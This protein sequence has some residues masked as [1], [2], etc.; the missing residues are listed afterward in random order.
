MQDSNKED[1]KIIVRKEKKTNIDFSTLENILCVKPSKLDRDDIEH[2]LGSPDEVIISPENVLELHYNRDQCTFFIHEDYLTLHFNSIKLN[3]NEVSVDQTE[4]SE[5][6]TLIKKFH[7][8]HQITY[9]VEV[10]DLHDEKM[11]TFDNIGLTVWFENQIINDIS[12]E[13]P[14]L[15]DN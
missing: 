13:F 6:I 15:V 2:V 1:L 11:M 3:D 14:C 7:R 8:N 5:F 9:K 4:Y 12:F 10:E